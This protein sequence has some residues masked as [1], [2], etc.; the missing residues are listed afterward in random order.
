MC[1][2]VTSSESSPA[3][4]GFRRS[5]FPSAGESGA[6]D[7]SSSTRVSTANQLKLLIHYM[8]FHFEYFKIIE[9]FKAYTVFKF[10]Y[11]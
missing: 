6:S 3:D 2:R 9:I 10:V 4:S 7:G 5:N 1:R 8:S 11:G